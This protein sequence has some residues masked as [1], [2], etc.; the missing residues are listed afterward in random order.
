MAPLWDG[1]AMDESGVRG[2]CEIA[3]LSHD[4]GYHLQPWLNYALLTILYYAT[5]RVVRK[6][7]QGS[8]RD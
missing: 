5:H 7:L 4:F 8:V 3:K 1:N 2:L 6:V